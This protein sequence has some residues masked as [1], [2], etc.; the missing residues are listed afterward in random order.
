MLGILASSWMEDFF[1]WLLTPHFS[2]FCTFQ[3]AN[4]P[5]PGK[6]W[7]RFT[8][9]VRI[10]TCEKHV[11][12]HHP[13]V[14]EIIMKGLIFLSRVFEE[15]TRLRRVL[16]KVKVQRFGA[17]WN[18]GVLHWQFAICILTPYK[19]MIIKGSIKLYK[20][21]VGLAVWYM[22]VNCL[23]VESY[24]KLKFHSTSGN[25]TAV[26]FLKKSYFSGALRIDLYANP[27]A[28]AAQVGWW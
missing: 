25:D 12:N 10:L 14:R 16:P 27:A 4:P 20:I 18:S 26:C 5:K 17:A 13:W 15:L 1:V 8:C 2:M 23:V 6:I 22:Q 3:S 19:I 24:W 11:L 21:Q 9:D 7:R 28:K